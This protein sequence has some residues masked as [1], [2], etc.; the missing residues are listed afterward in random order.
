MVIIVGIIAA[1]TAGIVYVY[2]FRG[3]A[4]YENL[5]EYFRKGWPIFSPLNC[6]L[7]MTTLP[8]ASRPVLD[9][10]AFPELDLLRQNWRTIRD[11]G[12]SLVRQNYFDANKRPGSAMFYDIG[13]HSFFKYGWSH[14]YINWYGYTHDS[15][16]RLC[17]KTVAI[18][19]SVPAVHGAM[20][21]YLP[22]RAQLKR[23]ADPVAI[24]L[25]YHLGLATPN[26]DHCFINVDGRNMS[27][28]DGDVLMFDETYLHFVRNET[29][30]DRLILMCDVKRPL[31]P[32]GAAFNFFY[33]AITRASVVP[34]T[35]EDKR[36][37]TNRVFEAVTP[38]LARHKAFKAKNRALY[39]VLK[40]SMTIILG[41]LLLLLMF[42]T[43]MQLLDRPA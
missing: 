2:R 14:F 30:V 4:R 43:L 41:I 9:P 1:M 31:N 12:L 28:R 15:A 26:S 29:D 22:K 16:K 38:L 10:A 32:L 7:Y 23:H 21:A 42:G 37:F 18:L 33:Q 11:E 39:L 3:E 25:R 17:P 20:F 5:A 24:S 6:I 34:N 19:Q 35:L 13:F 27:W 40:W 36:G 8:H